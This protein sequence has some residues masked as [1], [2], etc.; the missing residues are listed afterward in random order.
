M[1]SLQLT[2]LIELLFGC[3]FI[4][5]FQVGSWLIWLNYCLQFGARFHL[6]FL[7]FSYYNSLFLFRSQNKGG[8]SALK[9]MSSVV[10]D[11]DSIWLWRVFR[12]Q[13]VSPKGPKVVPGISTSTFFLSC[14]LESLF[15][16]CFVRRWISPGFYRSRFILVICFQF[17]SVR[18]SRPSFLS[19]GFTTW[20]NGCYRRYS[21][22]LMESNYSHKRNIIKINT[23]RQFWVPN[24]RCEFLQLDLT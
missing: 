14:K 17:S 22:F 3:H 15:G 8:I 11:F 5:F 18:M 4:N 10:V 20:V 2:Y 23:L 13:K 1:S 12:N 21:L 19:D 9:S 6:G 7:S 16:L 24:R